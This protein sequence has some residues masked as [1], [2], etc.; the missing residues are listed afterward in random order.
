MTA[1]AIIIRSVLIRFLLSDAL[2]IV[3]QVGN[4]LHEKAGTDRQA[5]KWLLWKD[6]SNNIRALISSLFPSLTA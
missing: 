3:H 5:G 2:G 4:I 6:Y 1:T